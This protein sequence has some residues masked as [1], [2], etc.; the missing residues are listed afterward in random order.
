MTVLFVRGLGDIEILKSYFLLVWTDEW[1]PIPSVISDTEDCIRQVFGTSGTEHHRR[2]L[3]ERLDHVLGQLDQKLEDCRER[4]Q[5]TL[6]RDLQD[7]R[8][9][10]AG[11]KRVLLEVDEQ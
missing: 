3:V 4:N 10:Y 6:E 7:A 5:L 11:F 2:E 8:A 1:T 9:R